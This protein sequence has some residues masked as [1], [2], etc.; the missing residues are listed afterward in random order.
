M[1]K[2]EI[3]CSSERQFS[4]KKIGTAKKTSRRS[5]EIYMSGK[6]AHV[7][8]NPCR[9]ATDWVILFYFVFESVSPRISILSWGGNLGLNGSQILGDERKQNKPH[10]TML[11]QGHI[12]QRVQS[13]QGSSLI[14]PVVEFP[15]IT[16]NRDYATSHVTSQPLKP[17][18]PCVP[19]IACTH[20]HSLVSYCI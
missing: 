1:P 2:G 10:S 4:I 13:S 9:P 6:L 5:L 11:R 14:E 8:Y 20:I 17:F 12:E 7:L 3:P 16:I 18:S 15:T 19:A